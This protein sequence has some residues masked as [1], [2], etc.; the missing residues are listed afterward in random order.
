MKPARGPAEPARVRRLEPL[1]CVLRATLIGL[2][3]EA[4]LVRATVDG[5]E[6]AFEG[7]SIEVEPG[8]QPGALISLLVKPSGVLQVLPA[9]EVDE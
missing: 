3:A 7:A 4:R 1:E 9:L 2:E 5:I 8:L 6:Y